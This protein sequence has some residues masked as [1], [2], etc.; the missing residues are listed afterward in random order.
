MAHFVNPVVS[1]D[2]SYLGSEIETHSEGLYKQDQG[3]VQTS[4]GRVQHAFQDVELEDEYA[5][6]GGFDFESY[7]ESLAEVTPELGQMIRWAASG[8]AYGFDAR[9][10]NDAVDSQDL[11][12]INKGLEQLALLYRD[13]HPDQPLP[14]SRN[15]ASEELT[16]EDESDEPQVD[17]SYVQQ[18]LETLR[19]TTYTEEQ[20][21]YMADV[22][23]EYDEGSTE[24][25]LLELGQVIGRGEMT[26]DEALN[27]AMQHVPTEQLITAYNAL[28]KRPN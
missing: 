25:F 2:G 23:A 26:F 8:E 10:F 6:Q 4:D 17:E 24:S 15:E 18:E 27:Y 22:Q 28:S 11:N 13:A 14:T 3:Y 1:E 5:L 20:V 7:A 21:E 9:S 12:E 19:N 16:D